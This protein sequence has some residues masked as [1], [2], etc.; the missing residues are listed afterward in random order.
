[1][2]LL[3]D[4]SVRRAARPA[5]T[6]R[7][8]R[9]SA[10][11]EPHVIGL[12]AGMILLQLGLHAW[13][14]AGGSLYSD[15]FA[16]QS[17]AADPTDTRFLFTLHDG[18]LM[19]G[20]LA[21]AWLTDLVA[22]MSPLALTAQVVALQ[23]LTS[24]LL[25]WLL[26]KAFGPRPLILVPL[27]FFL[28]SPMTL[29]SGL[30]WASAVNVLPM[31]AAL[32]LALGLH[33]SY[34]RTGRRRYAAGELAAVAG[35]L[36]FFEKS[37]LI[38]LAVV[39][40][41]LVVSLPVGAKA[42][43]WIGA[44]WRF[45][46]L[47]RTYAVLLVAYLVGY[48]ALN[49]R[50]SMV[51]DVRTGALE[52]FARGLGQAVVPTALGGPVTWVPVGSGSAIVNPPVWL[53]ILSCAALVVV[54]IATS[55][56]RPRARRAWLAM[57][58]Y[59]LVDLLVVQV[60]RGA[61]PFAP[62]LPLAL[63]YTADAAVVIALM[64]GLVLMPLSEETEEE[65][66]TEAR[67]VIADHPVRSTATATIAAGAFAVLC[68]V[69]T[70]SFAHI[71]WTTNTA[72]PWLTNVTNSLATAPRDVPL[73][74]QPV[75]DFVLFPLS[76]PANLTSHVFAAVRD[77]PPFATQTSRLQVF[78]ED[79]VLRPAVVVGVGSADPPIPG[80]WRV[81]NSSGVIRLTSSAIVWQHTLHLSYMS[82]S[83]TAGTVQLGSGSPVAVQFDRGI[84]DL[85]AQVSGG[86]DQ[87]AVT[88]QESS[89]VM[90]IGSAEVGDVQAAPAP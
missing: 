16:L 65:S 90:C 48:V 67:R 9:L 1:M 29:P 12:G 74:P 61:A 10:L 26:L 89:A 69:S 53:M 71:W 24:G 30:W 11:R 79:G 46:W 4:P 54:V 15:D 75:P 17:L 20:G 64:L 66:V 52:M 57:T 73:L 59:V 83:N 37:V 43:D 72:K 31:E 22:P 82:G 18:H 32:A 77:R 88:L 81:S 7:P 50:P 5:A 23:A 14:S 87:V 84:H 19:P 42:S 49:D 27:S 6:R 60:G 85:Y 38:V 39:L 51:G 25:L 8:V 58:A 34:L 80:C 55:E 70:A 13:L 21:L 56:V 63:R 76:Y 86:S 78:D 68:L 3:D 33:L 47:W 62:L 41:T 44:L 2:T 45:R 35:G 28:F 36:V 40:L